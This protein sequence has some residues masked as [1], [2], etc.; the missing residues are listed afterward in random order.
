MSAATTIVVVD[1]R[2][3]VVRNLEVTLGTFVSQFRPD[4]VKVHIR[5]GRIEDWDEEG[6][7]FVN[8]GNS[9]GVMDGALD[10]SLT[11]LM[12]GVENDVNAMI[13]TFGD[14]AANGDRYLPLF[15]SLLSRSS[16]NR[17]LI[18]SPCMFLPGPIDYRS[19]RNAFH[20]THAALSMLIWANRAGMGIRKLIMPGVCTGHGRMNRAQ[21]ASQMAD[22]FRAV[23]IDNKIIDDPT[24]ALHPR[25]LLAPSYE[26]QPFSPEHEPFLPYVPWVDANGKRELRPPPNEPPSHQRSGGSQDVRPGAAIGMPEYR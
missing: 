16:N 12:P 8:P 26:Y 11:A 18:T 5:K 20:A 24:Q 7:C 2:A 3:A 17:W 14:V 1:S 21:A 6:V 22:A 19:T 25:L 15:S 10:S 9:L 4:Q 23:F 13:Q